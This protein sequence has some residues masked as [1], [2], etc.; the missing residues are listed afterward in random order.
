MHGLHGERFHV[1]ACK[2]WCAQRVC[3]R[4]CQIWLHHG[5]TCPLEGLGPT[6]QVW[7]SCFSG[8]RF[9][10]NRCWDRSCHG[11]RIGQE[12]PGRLKL[13]LLVVLAALYKVHQSLLKSDIYFWFSGA[14]KKSLRAVFQSWAIWW[15]MGQLHHKLAQFVGHGRLLNLFF[16]SSQTEVWLPRYGHSKFWGGVVCK[17]KV[18]V[19]F[20]CSTSSGNLV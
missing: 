9:W 18:Y 11:R 20:T 1:S 10:A 14:P 17:N 7:T 8:T 5:F 15:L 16:G 4:L 13:G 3:S 2:L 19:W 6:F 12:H